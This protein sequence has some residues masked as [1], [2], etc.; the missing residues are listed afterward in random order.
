RTYMCQ[1][2]KLRFC[3]G[4]NGIVATGSASLWASKS[5]SSTAVASSEKTEKLTPPSSTVAPS[6]CG[7][8]RS[9][10]GS[11]SA[12]ERRRVLPVLVALVELN[13]VS[14]RVGDPGDSHAW[15]EIAHVE[16]PQRD[17]RIVPHVG[18]LRVE[19]VDEE[20]EVA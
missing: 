8:P 7:R 5:S 17:L 19:V 12:T 10:V 6:G 9:K 2:W 18:Q 15:D 4:S 14:F 16:G 13:D 20:R 3:T 11:R 1:K